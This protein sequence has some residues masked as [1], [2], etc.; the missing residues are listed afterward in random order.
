MPH[1][2]SCYRLTEALWKSS[3]A[4]L[5]FA[6]P[7]R[8]PI[9]LA[10]A[11]LCV[12]AAGA[13]FFLAAPVAP[14]TAKPQ[15]QTP[16]ETASVAPEKPP[17]EDVRAANDAATAELRFVEERDISMAP[18]VDLQTGTLP[19]ETRIERITTAPGLS[20]SAKARELL[21]ILTS[22]PEEAL[23]RATTEA[24]DR[25]PDK[26]YAD[27]AATLKNPQTHGR[28]LSVLFADVLER[29]DAIA[30]PTLLAIARTPTHPFA[31]TAKES[32]EHLLGKNP[33]NDWAAWDAEVRR[34]LK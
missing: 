18:R 21:R 23:E 9:L 34:A 11:A 27:A 16:P 10:A 33:G 30:M 4:P 8:T 15:P 12:V 3:P 32:L 24:A 29:P 5:R 17:S 19:W 28:V 14:T 20:D 2:R 7:M 6:Q 26:D 31:Q 22:L 1:K 25:L 13:Y